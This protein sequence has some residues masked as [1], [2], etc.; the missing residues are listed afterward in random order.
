MIFSGT[1]RPRVWAVSMIGVT[2]CFQPVEA[3]QSAELVVSPTAIPPDESTPVTLALRNTSALPIGVGALFFELQIPG[4]GLEVVGFEWAHPHLVEPCYFTSSNPPQAVAFTDACA[5][6]VSPGRQVALGQLTLLKPDGP[7]A[8]LILGDPGFILYGT[9]LLQPIPIANGT[10]WVTFSSASGDCCSPHRASGC[11]DPQIEAC[12][13]YFAPYC[14]IPGLPWS[15]I[16]V[17][18]ANDL[19]CGAF[20]DCNN[21]GQPDTCDAVLGPSE[22]CNQDSIPDE[23]VD[24]ADGD[25]DSDGEVTLYDYAWFV[26]CTANSASE[27]SLE[28]SCC[29]FDFDHDEDNDLLDFG[30][31]QR[32]FSGDGP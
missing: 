11:N 20:R 12:V 13:C 3:Q 14:C 19:G 25:Y 29:Q 32:L 26:V 1:R 27:A 23:C 9:P 2:L 16:C 4:G 24:P 18:A 28:T 15:Q 8:T 31:L 6:V 21:N 30:A 10:H 7:D 22:D 5:V 17:D